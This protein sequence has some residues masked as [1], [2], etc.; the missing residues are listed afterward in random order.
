MLASVAACSG[1]DEEARHGLLSCCSFDGPIVCHHMNERL[2]L[3]LLPSAL[4]AAASR[5]A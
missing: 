3:L 2:T 5:F 1:A 4:L